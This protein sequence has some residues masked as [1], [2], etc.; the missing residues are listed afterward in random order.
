MEVD[1]I[2]LVSETLEPLNIMVIEGWY[3]N[4]LK[5]THIT[6]HEY[7]ESEES[8]QDDE[9]SELEH[10]IQVDIWSKDSIESYNLKKQVRKLLK[11]NGFKFASG[12]DLFESD[13]KIYHK[14]LRFT[15]LEEV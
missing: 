6:V 7:L 5:K 14:G 9:A 15:Y 2:A 11:E 12:Q 8:F 3:D 1:I 13:T 4:E 10:N